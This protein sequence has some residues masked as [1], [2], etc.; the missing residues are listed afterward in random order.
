MIVA[1]IDYSMTSPAICIHQGSEWSIKNCQFFFRT[2]KKKVVAAST[3]QLQGELMADFSCNEER[4]FNNAEWARQKLEMYKPSILCL[5]GYAM[6]A[7]G[8]QFHIGESTGQLKHVMWK[9]G[10]SFETPPP[11][12]V[13]KFATGRGNAKKDVLE[14]AFLAETGLDIRAEFKGAQTPASFNPSSDI[15]D[16]YYMAKFAFYELLPKLKAT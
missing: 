7:T 4:Y 16:S 1:G 2:D 3:V 6:G 15:I 12:V 9:A 14:A 8:M 11:T 13:K 5:E 10:I